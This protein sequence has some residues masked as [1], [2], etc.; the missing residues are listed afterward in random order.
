M[1][2][3]DVLGCSVCVHIGTVATLILLFTNKWV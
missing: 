1:C 3:V 2:G